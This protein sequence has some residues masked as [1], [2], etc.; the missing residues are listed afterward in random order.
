MYVNQKSDEL[1]HYGRK[2]MKWGQNIFGK[3]RK[4]SNARRGKKKESLI[5]RFK[6]KQ[7]AKKRAAEE[8]KKKKAAEEEAKETETV[9]QKKSN[10]LKSRSA[11]E[12]YKNADLFDYKELDDAYKRLDLENRIKNLAPKEVDKATQFMDNAIKWSAKISSLTKTGIEVYNNTAK[13]YNAYAKVN[14]L[15]AWPIVGEKGGDGDKDNN[16]QN[17]QSKQNNQQSQGKKKNTP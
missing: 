3:K 5:T 16:N 17:N 15:D 2:G 9:E 1:C 13:I 14:K 4:S 12:L 10:V 11:K 8:A 6:A 7:E